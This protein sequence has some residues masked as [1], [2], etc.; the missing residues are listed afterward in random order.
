MSNGDFWTAATWAIF[1]GTPQT[2]AQNGAPAVPPTPGLLQKTM[3]PIQVVRQVFPTVLTGTDNS[4]PADTIDLKT[5]T[6]STGETRSFATLR[7]PFQLF[8]VHV[9]D[10]ALTMAANQVTLAGQALALVEDML[11][12][13][14]KNAPLP[15][16]GGQLVHLPAG[17][18]AKLGEGLLGIA[19]SNKTILVRREKAKETWGLATY[20]AVV[21]GIAKFTSDLQGPPYA[22]IVSPKIFADANLPLPGNLLVTPSSAIQA[23]L[24]TRQFLMSPALSDG[25]GLFASLGGY[26]TMLYNGTGPLVE[27]N[28]YDNSVYSFTARE[29]IQFL[30]V[31]SRSLIVLHFDEKDAG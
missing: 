12:F 27:Y 13:H 6:P 7:K 28:A 4:I 29:S 20:S 2:T 1:N 16:A 18:L 10:P 24:G 21:E 15:K 14:G 30:N 17:D 25:R 23:L 3:A 5:G 9:N 31:D 26:T 22:L 8:P 19:A 11:F